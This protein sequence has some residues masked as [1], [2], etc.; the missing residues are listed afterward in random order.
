MDAGVLDCGVLGEDR[1]P[2][3]ALERIRVERA[4]LPLLALA[5]D[6]T[7]AKHGIDQRRLAVVDVGDDRDVSDVLTGLHNPSFYHKTALAVASLRW[8]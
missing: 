6:P 8:V 2:A 3:L 7:L 1:D 4:H 5:V